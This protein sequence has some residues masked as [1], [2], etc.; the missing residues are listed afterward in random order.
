MKL[1]S[2]LLYAIAAALCLY[3]GFS[4]MNAPPGGAGTAFPFVVSQGERVQSVAGNLERRGYVRSGYFFASLVRISGKAR[5]IKAG[6]YELRG[7]MRATDI[8][9]VLSRG[10]VATERF[11]VP[12]GLHIGQV[13]EILDSDGIVP[14]EEFIKACSDQRLLQKYGIPFASAEGFL[15]PDTYVVAKGLGAAQ[16]AERMI[17]KFFD[18][19]AAMPFT[20]YDRDELRR[21]VIIASLVEK[22]AKLDDERALIS[23]VFF[24]RLRRGKRLESCATVQYILQKPKERLLFSDL[25]VDS[26]YNTYL[27]PGLP[28]GPISNPGRKSL[29][30]AARPAAVG[31]LFF[32]SKMDGSHHFSST[33]E[34]HLKAIRRYN[35]AGSVG[36][37]VS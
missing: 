21:V 11:T 17:R 30:A 35:K 8:I 33:Y 37:Q 20:D 15:F 19:L 29:A 6:E 24:N 5:S 14:S 7:D 4:L 9:R 27:H 34:E 2:A 32:V 25:K 22:E 26:P 18:V 12:E 1:L 23:A 31:Y 28:P 16:I 13:A 3:L 10:E 36:H